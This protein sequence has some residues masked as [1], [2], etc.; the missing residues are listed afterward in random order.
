MLG[1]EKMLPNEKSHGLGIQRKI[2]QK[3]YRNSDDF[4]LIRSPVVMLKT[5]HPTSATGNL[6]RSMCV[7][8][9]I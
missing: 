2:V 9:I 3:T 7:L 8:P 6:C 1:N 4:G 5:F